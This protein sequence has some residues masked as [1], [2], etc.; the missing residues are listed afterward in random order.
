MKAT[1]DSDCE[2][3]NILISCNPLVFNLGDCFVDY[4]I[5]HHFILLVCEKPPISFF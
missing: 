1:F 4:E 5:F 3:T 2:L